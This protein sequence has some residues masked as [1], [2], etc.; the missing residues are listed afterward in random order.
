MPEQLRVGVIGA[1]NM[2]QHHIRNYHEMPEVELVAIADSIADSQGQK[3]AEKYHTAFYSDYE[4]MLEV[5]RPVA[6][7]VAVPTYL[8]HEVASKTL[9][10]GIHTLV[11]KPIT[12]DEV[13]AAELIEL[14]RQ[15]ETV[16]TVGHIERYNPV[17]LELKKIIDRGELGTV[18]SIISQRLGGFPRIEPES[19][20]VVDL[21]IHDIDIISYLMGSEPDIIG[22]HGTST[23]HSSETD[24]A[25]I[26]LR[27]GNAS[28][29][30]QANWTSPVKIRQLSITGSKGYVTVNYITQEITS[31]EHM[32][33]RNQDNFDQ[34]V[35]L[36]GEPTKKSIKFEQDE[37]SEP[38]RR[39]LGAFAMAAA[40]EQPAMLVSPIDAVA[41][42]HTA[43]MVTEQIKRDA[44]VI[45]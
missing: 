20:V 4:E 43:L 7:S 6:V 9:A 33:I 29:F 12:K 11:E 38:L 1:G 44:K 24:S 10:L 21:A 13:Q 35:K 39:E 27:Y 40:G 28:G 14:A 34:F 22:A 2:G 26:L 16:L 45:V 37:Q 25:E 23:F 19:D 32:A 30:V 41:A 15:H 42:L 18:S 8:H 5:A 31:Y 17:V 3:L 36:L